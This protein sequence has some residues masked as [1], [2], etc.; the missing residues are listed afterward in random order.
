M[1]Y[2]KSI[3]E[4]GPTDYKKAGMLKLGYIAEHGHPY[5]SPCKDHIIDLAEEG[6]KLFLICS[7]CGDAKYLNVEED[8]RVQRRRQQSREASRNSRFRPI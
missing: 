1:D 2:S 6:K 4:W 8:L 5:R 7:R 3:T